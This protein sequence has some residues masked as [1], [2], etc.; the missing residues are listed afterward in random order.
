MATMSD[1]TNLTVRTWSATATAAGAESYARYF[2]DALLPELRKLPGFVG[3]YLLGG[4][5]LGTPGADGA[6]GATV[7]LTAC[8]FWKSPEAIRAFTGADITASVVEPEARAMLLDFD[9]T[10]THRDVL[11]DARS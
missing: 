3:A 4:D 6:D 1:A 10:A 11:V 7:K 8:T 9:R 2:A 5:D